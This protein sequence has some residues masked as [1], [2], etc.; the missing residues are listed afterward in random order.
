MTNNIKQQIDKWKNESIQVFWGEIAPCDHLVQIYHNDTIFLNTLE[1]F[2]TCG[3]LAGGGTWW[4]DDV[5]VLIDH[6]DAA[7]APK[8]RQ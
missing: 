7:D 1:G 8:K 4:V 3:L 5:Q 6:K 2:A